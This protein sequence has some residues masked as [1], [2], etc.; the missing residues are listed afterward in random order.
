MN[1]KELPLWLL[2]QTTYIFPNVSP[3]KMKKK[4][5]E[6]TWLNAIHLLIAYKR[7]YKILSKFS[8]QIKPVFRT[9]HIDCPMV[10]RS[11]QIGLE[12]RWG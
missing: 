1:L 2:L 5:N 8:M 9:L 6:K 4:E 12:R 7:V 11:S 3:F 10:L